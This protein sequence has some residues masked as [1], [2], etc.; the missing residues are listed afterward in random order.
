MQLKP[1]C[2]ACLY[3]QALRVSKVLECDEECADA[4]MQRSASV[5]AQIS[6]HQTPP[7]A[8]A[9]LYPAI[10]ELVGKEDLYADKKKESIQ[11]AQELIPYVREKIASSPNRLDA[12]L[13]A[14]VAGNVID[15]ATQVMFDIKEEIAKIFD[16]PFAI[17]RK[18]D[19]IQK[20]ATAKN[21]LLIGDNVG[22][23]L[24]DK[25][26]LETIKEFYDI[27]LY[28]FVRGKPIINDVTYE[29]A[30]AIGLDEVCE[31]VDS[32]VYTPGFIY[33]KANA[34]AKAIYDEA[35]LILA[36]GMGNFECMES[37]EDSRIFFLFKVKCSVVANRISKN[38][39][40]LICA[41]KE[42]I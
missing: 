9:A 31:V 17:D 19:F 36:K 16:T 41:T 33:E 4:I 23:H 5:L 1:D 27:P 21:L 20:L 2:F 30:L 7:E 13:R 8:A 22:E 28:Y 24:F 29:D 38:I 39:G 11:K 26:L 3:N 37:Y 14:A 10:S 35:D 40:D 32:S 6:V 18:S 12:A 34:K 42:D 15:F 25:V